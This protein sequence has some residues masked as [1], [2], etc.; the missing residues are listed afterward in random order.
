[1]LKRYFNLSAEGYL[2]Q[3][4]DLYRILVTA[5]ARCSTIEATC[6]TLEGP[7]SNTVRGYI[8]AELRPEDI[9]T[10]QQ[11]CNRALYSQWPHWLWSQPLDLAV[12]LH[13]EEYYGEPEDD[14]PDSWVCR[15][16]KRNGTTRFYRCA[17]LSVIHSQVQLQLA[18]VFVHPDAELVDTLKTLVKYVRSRGLR[19]RCLYADKQFATIPVL[20]YLL[21]ET[22][23]SAIIAVPRKGKDGG[24]NALCHGRCSYR[25]EHTFESKPYGRLTVPVGIVR[26]FKQDHGTRT[27]TWLVYALI[28]IEMSLRR[29]RETYRGRFGIDT[30][31]RCME[32]VR[33]RT[34][35]KNPAFRFF[36]MSLALVLVN[37]WIAFQW[38]Y[39]RLRGSGPRRIARG[40]LTL[41]CMAFF[42]IHAVET[43]YGVV[44]QISSP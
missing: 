9:A 16:E 40:L 44:T 11:A 24:V 31:Y 37:V 1:V 10:L 43:Y 34:T 36:L 27:L 18:V 25:T 13:D 14:D 22:A 29:V 7:D 39:C 28:R 2:C 5:A 35:S 32:Q 8:Q 17:T 19:I 12:D 21:T 26:A 15:G 38:T 41:A 20:R 23:L 42:L 4:D 3:T 30:K 6:K 33:A